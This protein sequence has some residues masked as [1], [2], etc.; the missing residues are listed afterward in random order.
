M[1][2]L[3]TPI[4]PEIEACLDAIDATLAGEPVDPRHAELAELAL[5]LADERPRPSAE[6]AR[7]LDARVADRFPRPRATS[8]AAG[9]PRAASLRWSGWWTA[10][11]V[12]AALAA[13]VIAVVVV[14]GG[15]GG[16][17]GIESMSSSSSAAASPEVPRATVTS[18]S[19]SAGAGSAAGA[20]SSSKTLQGAHAPAPHTLRQFNPAVKSSA[21]AAGASNQD[22]YSAPTPRSSG[23]LA[24]PPNGRKV[25]QSAE[26]DL[27]A[28]P[29]QIDTVAQEVF[30]V[31]GN[32]GGIVDHSSVTQTGGPDGSAS[33][34]LRLPSQTLAQTLNRLSQ[35]RGAAVL[36]RTDNSQDINSQYVSASRALADAQALRSALLKQLA[37][38]VTTAQIDSLN[39]RIHDTE[40]AIAA[41]Q[42]AVRNLN[43]RVDY[44]QVTVTIAARN[45]PPA[46][47]S[48]KH[49]GFTLGKA[50]HTAGRVLVVAAGVAL[51]ALAALVPI[52]LV[53]ALLLW[54]GAALRRRRREQALDLA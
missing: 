43:A 50:A 52:G 8:G 44:S 23:S 18:S 6:F 33:F 40:Q 9:A 49:G 11:S 16:G 30:I 54:V 2:R 24:L 7:S 19:S 27:A 22:L 38:A 26:I 47:A 5:L 37:A 17:S 34:S 53:L 3:D 14:A 35:L 41:D 48:H 46:P 36:S 13:A 42:A 4:D 29:H 39:A 32:A 51:I 45:L 21:G 10:G 28:D 31:V 12:A 1:R 25:I 15:G 20:S